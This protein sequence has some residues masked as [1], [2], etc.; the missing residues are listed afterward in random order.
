MRFF[1]T[2]FILIIWYFSTS[3]CNIASKLFINFSSPELYADCTLTILNLSMI[4]L[5]FGTFLGAFFAGRIT[6]AL[7]LFRLDKIIAELP[8]G[9][10]WL[11]PMKNTM[12]FTGACHAVGGFSLNLCY[13]YSSVFIVQVLKCAEPVATLTLGIAILG[14]VN[15]S[16]FLFT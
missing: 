16:F 13:L 11:Q 9:F 4:Q 8:T 7:D 15:I 1:V 5:V 12:V 14:E 3:A 10:I 2:V 6:S